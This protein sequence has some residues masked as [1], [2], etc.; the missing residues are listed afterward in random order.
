[1]DLAANMDL[2]RFEAAVRVI[3]LHAAGE[4]CRV[5]TGGFPEPQGATMIEKRRW[6]EERCDNLRR[7]LMLEPRGHGN[8][9][10]ALVCEPVHLEAQLGVVFMDTG[11][12]LN[13]CGHGTM[14]VAAA[15]VEAGLV[16][17]REGDNE[18]VLDAP[19]GLVRARVCVKGGRAESVSLENVPS[20]VLRDEAE[21]EVD[22]RIVPLT[23]A[24]GGSF[25]ALVDASELDLGPI[26][27]ETALVYARLGELVRKA[28]NDQ[29]PIKHPELDIRT[30]DLVEFSQP[31][32]DPAVADLRHIVV[33]GAG[34]VDRSPCGT[35]LSAKL[36]A[37]HRR[38]EIALG[39]P[40]V[41]ES[42]IGTR[43]TGVI[44][45]EATVGGIPA[46]VPRI[47]GRAFVTGVG[48]CLVDPDDPLKHGFLP[49][50]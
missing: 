47:S 29:V 44:E 19:A 43:F 27:P 37:L 2:G 40:L 10:G 48:T 24:F 1:M 18:V 35:G 42:F 13:M 6:M 33:F 20:F 4:P 5:A 50:G 23:I 9:F 15:A 32:P 7:A 17:A 38:G 16:E 49:L 25:F 12:Y 31:A 36:A 30:V 34:S 45:R 46:V 28:V 39:Q 14:A 22:G 3:D 26:G 41:C 21:V 11:G 8:M